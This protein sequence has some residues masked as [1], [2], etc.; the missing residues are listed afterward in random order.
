[1][2]PPLTLVEKKDEVGVEV[3]VRHYYLLMCVGCPFLQDGAS[4]TKEKG[5]SDTRV[6]AFNGQLVQGD[7][8]Y[9]DKS[10]KEVRD[11][12]LRFGLILGVSKPAGSLLFLFID[13]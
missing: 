10:K 7:D 3:W 2:S 11:N 4:I 13:G 5:D 6:E 12:V 9:N 1:M 8:S